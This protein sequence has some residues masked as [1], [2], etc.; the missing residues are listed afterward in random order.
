MSIFRNSPRAAC[1][2]CRGLSRA[3][4]H[5]LFRAKEPTAWTLV[6]RH[7]LALYADLMAGVRRALDE[8]TFGHFRLA[9]KENDAR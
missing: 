8:G 7:N 5:H 4:L 2:T 3:Y 1:A 6:T 9:W